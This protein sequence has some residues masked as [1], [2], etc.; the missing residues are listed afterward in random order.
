[1]RALLE[2]LWLRSGLAVAFLGK[3]GEVGILA[4]MKGESASLLEI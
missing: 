2:S 4:L 1:M 3:S